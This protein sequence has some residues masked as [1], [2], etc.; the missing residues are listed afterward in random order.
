MPDLHQPVSLK[1]PPLCR[2]QPRIVKRQK[3]ISEISFRLTDTASIL[4]IPIIGSLLRENTENLQRNL[5]FWGLLSFF[6]VMLITTHGG[7]RAWSGIQFRQQ[8]KLAIC[9]FVATST[10]MLSLAAL[11][12][13]GHILTRRWT[14]ADLIITPAIISSG[15]AIL[16]KKITKNVDFSLASGPLVICYDHCPPDLPR[17]LVEQ[18]IAQQIT[19]VL[20]LSSAGN[21]DAEQTKKFSNIADVLEKIQLNTTQDIIFVHHPILDSLAGKEHQML[22]SELLAYPARI[23]LAF[24]VTSN[25]PDLLKNH[26]TSCKII[27]IV[28]NDLVSSLNLTKRIFDIIISLML[29]FLL[30]PVFVV[31]TILVK[32]SGPGPVIFRQVRTGAHGQPFTVLKFRTMAY[33]PDQKFFQAQKKDPRV[34]PQGRFLRRSSIDELLQIFNVIRGDMSL[35]GPRPHAPETEVNGI[36]FENAIKLYRLR[37]RVK[38]GITGLAQIRG[39]RGETRE[40]KM[41]EQRLASDLEY[42]Q[43]WS[44][45]QDILI[46]LKTLPIMFT[47]KNAW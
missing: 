47:Q 1:R 4:I 34:T 35:V 21:A 32:A 16:D 3:L 38:P 8:T 7:Y 17:A 28:T 13:H 46:L 36:N 26:S 27:P 12:G 30:S 37:H 6:T 43:S 41:L 9:C 19:S 40:I 23:W 18:N 5:C 39:Q 15:R 14:F 25:V 29:L 33:Q 20:Y 2:L 22:L 42:I 24:D 44:L 31:A 11:L 45:W 10:A